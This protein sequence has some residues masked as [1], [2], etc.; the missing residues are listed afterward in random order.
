M[1]RFS[2]TA[3]FDVSFRR[4]RADLRR[5][6]RFPNLRPRAVT[7]AGLRDSPHARLERRHRRDWRS[8]DARLM[9]H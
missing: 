7:F 4:S 9:S 5:A 2:R 8:I 1:T 6:V 3:I